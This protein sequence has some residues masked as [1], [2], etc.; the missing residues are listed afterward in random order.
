MSRYLVER[1][2]PEAEAPVDKLHVRFTLELP[3]NN[4]YHNKLHFALD[5][6]R[7]HP[8][9]TPTLID[10]LLNLLRNFTPGP[11]LP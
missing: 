7:R 6:M 4:D 10:N 3:E 11:K 8:D 1:L 2:A 5:W 9:P